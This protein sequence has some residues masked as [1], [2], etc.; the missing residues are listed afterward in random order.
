MNKKLLSSTGIILVLGFIT[1]FIVSS[2]FNKTGFSNYK[3]YAVKYWEDEKYLG[4]VFTKKDYTS[5]LAS[6]DS[7]C[8]I[9]SVPG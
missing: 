9:S 6:T 3:N 2:V 8:Q 1:L 5:Y 4:Y 7:L